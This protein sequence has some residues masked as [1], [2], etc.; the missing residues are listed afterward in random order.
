MLSLF[1]FCIAV[2]GEWIE[3]FN[4]RSHPFE[5]EMVVRHRE[6]EEV[7][8][9]L[10]LD[11]GVHPNAIV[12]DICLLGLRDGIERALDVWRDVHAKGVMHVSLWQVS[13]ES[14]EAH[15]RRSSRL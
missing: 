5:L 11:D 13:G 10:L 12:L 6:L 1:S 15:N 8:G 2:Y 7:D 3:G 14:L 4:I 9:E